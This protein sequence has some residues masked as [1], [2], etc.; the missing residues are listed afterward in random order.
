M[1]LILLGLLN[2][3]ILIKK[4]LHY[5]FQINLIILF[6]YPKTSKIKFK[7]I[8]KE[9]FKFLLIMTG[10]FY[11]LDQSMNSHSYRGELGV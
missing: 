7:K 3:L 6:Y 11:A 4:A 1:R 8:I 5:F 10:I 9:N 2:V